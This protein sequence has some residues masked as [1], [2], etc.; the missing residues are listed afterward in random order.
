MLVLQGRCHNAPLASWDRLLGRMCV[1]VSVLFGL[2]TQPASGVFF[3]L[4][5]FFT[6]TESLELRVQLHTVVPRLVCKLWQ[7]VQKNPAHEPES[8]F[9]ELVSKKDSM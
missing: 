7:A 1:R 5:F 3:S 4:F 9:L 8:A 6:V 2:E